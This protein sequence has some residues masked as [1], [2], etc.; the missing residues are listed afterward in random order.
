VGQ[1]HFSGFVAFSNWLRAD[2]ERLLPREIEL[3]RNLS[4]APDLHPVVLIFGDQA[5]GATIFAGLTLPLGIHYQEFGIA[6]PFVKHRQGS[7]LHTYVPCMYSS[8]FPAAWSGNANYGFSKRMGTMWWQGPI[9]LLTSEQGELL[10]HA[11]VESASDWSR[12]PHR[13]LANFDALQEIFSM[14]ILG[15]KADGSYVCS[16]FG[17]DFS[18]ARVRP[19]DSCLSID[20]PLLEGLA[21]R[22]CHDVPSGTFEIRGMIWRLT[23][24]GACRF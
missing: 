10:F 3:A 8:Y 18:G 16:Y 13:G 11:A 17:W 5:A 12:P 19:A 6:V 22:R 2:V 4:S 20:G 23:W 24:P 1:A 21:P 15:C 7:N 9:F 14:P